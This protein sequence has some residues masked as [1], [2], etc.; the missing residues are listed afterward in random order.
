MDISS[1]FVST[2]P[3]V[4]HFVNPDERALVRLPAPSP[5]LT[6]PQEEV[7]ELAASGHGE[8]EKQTQFL[9]EVMARRVVSGG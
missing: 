5:H 6:S 4:L 8:L 3:G 9:A 7:P 2:L 1:F